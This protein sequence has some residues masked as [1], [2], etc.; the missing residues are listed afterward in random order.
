MGFWEESQDF[1]ETDLAP[2]VTP[3]QDPRPLSLTH[4]W[5]DPTGP[6]DHLHGDRKPSSPTALWTNRRPTTGR[7][8]L[9]QRKRKGKDSLRPCVFLSGRHVCRRRRLWHRVGG[10]PSLLVFA[11]GESGFTFVGTVPLQFFT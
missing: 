7:E 11:G 5:T 4:P 8:A 9:S 10:R 2:E 1:G 6:L 3:G